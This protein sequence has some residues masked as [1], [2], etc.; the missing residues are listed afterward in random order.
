MLPRGTTFHDPDAASAAWECAALIAGR[1][2]ERRAVRRSGRTTYPDTAQRLL[3]ASRPNQPTAVM[4]YTAAATLPVLA[5]DFDAKT[6]SK[7]AQAAADAADAAQLLTDAG[8]SPVLDQAPS[9]GWHVYA[10]LPRPIPARAVRQLAA[11]LEQRWTTFDKLPLVTDPQ[12][13]C[14]RPPGSPHAAGG[15]QTL[16]TPLP[17]AL[18]AL[19]S[20]PDA[21]SW[22]RL[23]HLA[24][25][26]A[27]E[28]APIELPD[29]TD[30]T[31]ATGVRKRPL[32]NAATQM[33]RTGTHP[34]P[35]HD[36]GFNSPSERR[37]SIL[38]S[39]VNAGWTLPEV[40]AALPDWAWLRDSLATKHHS[41]LARDWH[42]AQKYRTRDLHNRH[43]RI[44][45]TSHHLTQ[46]GTPEGPELALGKDFDP[47]L[48]IRKLTTA[49]QHY[50]RRHHYSPAQRATLRALLSMGHKQ[51]RIYINAG[52]RSLAEDAAHS[53]ETVAVHLH[54]FSEDGLCTRVAEAQGTDADTWRL[55]IELG[56][57]H[58]PAPG[59]RYGTR[60]VF[61]ILGHLAADVY[62]TLASR[63]NSEWTTSGLADGLGY[64][65]RRI[66]ETLQLLASYTLASRN[67]QQRTWTLGAADP[68][69]LGQALG[70]DDDLA[71]H[72]QRHLE[73][74]DRWKQRLSRQQHLQNEQPLWDAEFAAVTPDEDE[75][76]EALAGGHP[77]TRA[78]LHLV[79]DRLGARPA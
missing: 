8:L 74:R 46:G 12:R 73:H 7:R 15:Y 24:G 45:D 68:T 71:E 3:S 20:L 9:G 5:L 65:R 59:R 30:D 48:H 54:Q 11:A 21:G 4:L 52:C 6:P 13:A 64:D 1:D 41:A 42:A 60:P 28:A 76:I 44:P 16:A 79:I 29:H 47:H 66:H 77:P 78:A 55:A 53:H 69:A 39:A 23:R 72:H 32:S 35:R 57:G 61:R 25:A 75:W 26:A 37:L 34:D 62:E 40:H 43:V 31:A 56:E 22:N 19:Q 18:T 51:G 27:Y 38:R 2:A 33:A 70:G 49:S 63:P 58:S 14:I 17:D 36:R 10:R 50:A 67:P